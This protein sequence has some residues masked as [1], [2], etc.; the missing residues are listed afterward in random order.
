VKVVWHHRAQGRCPS[1]A[2]QRA[3]VM[4]SAAA[5]APNALAFLCRRDEGERGSRGDEPQ[6]RLTGRPGAPRT[7]LLTTATQRRRG[8]LC[9]CFRT[10]RC[11]A[12]AARRIAPPPAQACQ[13]H[14][15]HWPPSRRKLTSLLL[16][17]SSWFSSSADS[18]VHQRVGQR[19]P[20]ARRATPL[21]V[22]IGA[23]LRIWLSACNSGL[24]RKRDHRLALLL[25]E[26]PSS[27]WRSGALPA[28]RGPRAVGRGAGSTAGSTIA[29]IR[30]LRR[31][32]RSPGADRACCRRASSATW[33]AI[34]SSHGWSVAKP[35]QQSSACSSSA[36][37]QAL[38]VRAILHVGMALCSPRRR[39]SPLAPPA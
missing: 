35:P 37:P 2:G 30:P 14:V 12:S 33:R 29:S 23:L 25:R 17:S 7:R 13:H 19:A 28:R 9:R 22:P 6:T 34:L 4:T 26:A 20:S 18:P 1:G 5:M 39:R 3:H 21:P 8:A 36:A 24:P 27:P 38:L 10:R 16:G 32:R 31:A 15:G 11:G